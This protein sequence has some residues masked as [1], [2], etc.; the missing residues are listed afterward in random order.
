MASRRE[1]DDDIGDDLDLLCQAAELVVTTQFGS[2]SMLQRKLRV[3]FAKAGRLMDLMESRGIVGPSEGSKARDVLVKPDELDG[4]LLILRGGWGEFPPRLATTPRGGKG[5]APP[6]RGGTSEKIQP[7]TRAVKG[8]GGGPFPPPRP[9]AARGR[10]PPPPPEPPP[11]PA[12]PPPHPA[13]R[14]GRLCLLGGGLL[15][16]GPLQKPRALVGPPPAPPLRGFDRLHAP[17]APSASEVFEAETSVTRERRG[18]NWTA[19]M[20][21]VLVLVA[22]FAVYQFARGGSTAANAGR[23]GSSSTPAPTGT[24]PT[25]TPSS[26]PTPTISSSPSPT[27]IAKVPSTTQ[28]VTVRLEVTTGRTWISA[29]GGGSKL[30]EGVLS[31][32]AVKVFADPSLVKLVIGNAGAVHLIVNGVDLGSPG[33]GGQVVRLSFH[34]GDPTASG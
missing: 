18:P 34:P 28:G 19:A 8:G 10:A 23:S 3:G 29:T 27:V 26:T 12:P 15:P 24:V 2:T 33:S 1:V 21:A 7:R 4:M 32:G 31:N 20:A 22:I 5:G 14:G 13:P 16:P 30:Y 17:S 25:P 11:P 6:P 9:W